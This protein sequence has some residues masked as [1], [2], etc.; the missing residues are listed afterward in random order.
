M[1]GRGGVGT[2]GTVFRPGPTLALAT[3]LAAGYLTPGCRSPASAPNTAPTPA[4][5]APV[6]TPPPAEQP[7]PAHAT[8]EPPAPPE[9]PPP[10]WT[11]RDDDPTEAE[12]PLHNVAALAPFYEALAR[13]D[14]GEVGIARVVHLGASMIG[15]D[16][17]TSVLRERFQSR[18]GDG[19]AGLVLLQRYMPNYRHRGVQL[20]ADGWTHCYI[21]YLCKKDGHYGLG[22][23]TFF[24]EAG[25]TTNVRTLRDGL[26][27]T[28]SRFE[29]WYAAGPRGGRFDV[30]VDGGERELV[31]TRADSLEDRY[32]ALDVDA[33][34]HA[35]EIRARGHGRVRGYGVV[36]ETDGPGVVWDQFSMLGA[37][38][39]RMLGWSPEHIAG[40]IAHR[41]PHLIAFMYGGNDLR[42]VA[43][44]KLDHDQYVEE[45]LEAVRRVHAGKLE[46]A[47]LIIGIT[48]RGK[49]L[50]FDIV[51]EH[52]EVI[53]NAQRE[54]ADKA[55]CAF[56]DTY[57]AMGGGGSLKAWR[58]ASPPLAAKDLKHLNHRGR[59][60]LGGW[61]YDA[62]VAG[63]V[64]HR[65]RQNPD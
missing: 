62:I 18:F 41:D 64:G 40:Q 47:C 50:K 43:T 55:G 8:P 58:D 26:G 21:A 10:A 57:A 45:Y 49:S 24:G 13:V 3:A 2:V 53:V 20:S 54:V 44:G 25:A 11:P 15:G 38:T 35:I 31:D 46:S 36:L 39:K 34:S 33:G 59:V 63:Y 19:G 29:V 6:A 42:R 51:P 1:R 9:P 22:G 16:D 14:D 28:V 60:R 48:D 37:F 7:V 23:A 17:L 56:F 65:T 30:R 32:H 4:S 12:H 27:S 61:I 52:V 5:V